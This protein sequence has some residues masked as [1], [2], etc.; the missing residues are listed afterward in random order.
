MIKSIDHIAIPIESVEAMLDFYRALGF[1]VKED[2]PDLFY[3][4]CFGDNKI[5]MHAP[6]LW[7][8]PNFKLRGHHAMPGSAD[9]C[10]VW[11]ASMEELIERLDSA[12][13]RIEQ[14]PVERDG[15]Q[16]GGRKG[17]SVYT[18]DPDSNL[19]EFIVY[20]S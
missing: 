19:L 10:F 12:N 3:S 7:Q 20:Q 13:A 9:I 11:G 5:N 4:A 6:A 17:Q 15:A 18:R 1:E 16:G 14:G 2:L 8:D